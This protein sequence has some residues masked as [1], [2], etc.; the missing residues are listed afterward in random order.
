M[1]FQNITDEELELID[2][3]L[4]EKLTEGESVDFHNRW[5]SEPDF[6][7]KVREV[8]LA[9]MAIAEAMLEVEMQKFQ[10][11]PTSF[12]EKR[13]LFSHRFRLL[14]IIVSLV[15]VVVIS[16]IISYT[17][18]P[19]NIRLYKQYFQPDP[20]LM[21]TMGNTDKYDFE[22]AM[23]EYKEGKYQSAIDAWLLL[24]NLD[25]Q[26]DTIAYFIGAAYQAIEKMDEA[27]K[28]L[29]KVLENPQ[30]VFYKDAN[31]YLGLIAIQKNDKVAAIRY[32]ETSENDK[33][34]KLIEG[35]K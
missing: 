30:S 23:I 3:F 1:N 9:S 19:Y 31:W 4:D 25:P 14:T 21:T 35:L 7:K 33:A 26:N 17:K 5:E 18:V 6:K 8:R 32:L 20:G 2:K 34:Q 22:K 12:E 11:Q 29:Y 15:L 16:K 27:Q 24:G 13:K 10:P 28:Y